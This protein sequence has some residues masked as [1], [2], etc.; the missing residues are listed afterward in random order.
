MDRQLNLDKYRPRVERAL[1]AF[2]T[3]TSYA[4]AMAK[5]A[6]TLSSRQAAKEA[7]QA[8]ASK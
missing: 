4:I 2:R 1:L 5:Q 7:R 8:E 6:G 3:D